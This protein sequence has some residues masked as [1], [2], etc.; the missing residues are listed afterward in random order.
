MEI[1]PAKL[2]L[3]V[4]ASIIVGIAIVIV[5]G[6]VWMFSMANT[7]SSVVFGGDGKRKVVASAAY[8]GPE[9][10]YLG[11]TNMSWGE[12]SSHNLPELATG[13]ARIFGTTMADG[14]PLP[15]LRL[16][17]ALNSKA[18]SQWAVTDASGR[19]EISIPPGKYL[20][21]G[22]EFDDQ[23]ANKLLPGKI[24]RPGCLPIRCREDQLPFEATAAR[25]GAGLNFEF[26]DPVE[27]LSPSGE[28]AIGSEL[29]AR[30]KAFPGAARY[31][32]SL[33]ETPPRMMGGTSKPVFDWRARPE[34]AG[35]SLDLIKVG[36]VPKAGQDY[37][38]SIEALD[39]KGAVLS[40]SPSMKNLGRFRLVK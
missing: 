6:F 25:P 38:I 2:T 19:Y 37:S 29:I 10:V 35:E 4:I 8:D 23:A 12:K 14:K 11:T 3:I 20:V 31:R 28:I 32:V 30:W 15:G 34:V 40:E 22:F 1:S 18:V 17:L 21:S 16:R 13:E 27:L 26:I 9:A 5:S 36:L 39:E 7:G 24:M 33:Q